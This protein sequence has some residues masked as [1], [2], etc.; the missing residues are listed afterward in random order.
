MKAAISAAFILA[1]LFTPAAAQEA[2]VG[3]TLITPLRSTETFLIDM[4]TSTIQTWHGDAGAGHTVYMLPDRSV[5]RSQ[6]DPNGLFGGGGAGGHLQRVDAN[7]NIVWDFFFSNDQHQQHHDIEPMPNGNV[8]LIAWE[9]K[10]KAEVI[11]AGRTTPTGET[12]FPTR[13]VELEPVGTN[14]AKIVWEWTLWDHLIQDNDPAKPNYGVIADHPELVDI[15]L[16]GTGRSWDHGNYVDY[17]PQR[18]QIVFS[19]RRMNE[20]YVIDHSTTIGEAAGHTGGNSGKGG[21]ILYRWGNPQNYGRGTASDQYFWGVHGANWINHGLPG[22]GG[23]LAFNNGNRPSDENDL[24]SVAE[25]QPP[26]DES[27]NYIISAGQP[28]GPAAPDW[29]YAPESPAFFSIRYG[30]AYRMPNG[31]T[32]ICD[33]VPGILFELTPDFDKVWAYLEPIGRGIFAA[34]R[35]WNVPAEVANFDI[36]PRSCPNPFNIKWLENLDGN[37]DAMLMKGGVL[38]AAIAGSA[39][40]D[41]TELDVATLRLRGIAPLLSSYQDV[42]APV[43]GDACDCTTAGPDGFTDLTL[44]FSRQEIASVLGPV[45]PGDVVTL[46]ITGAMLDGALFEATDCVTILGKKPEPPSFA[47]PAEDVLYPA[48]PNP[49]NPVTVIRYDVRAPGRVSLAV[50]DVAGRLV[51]TLVDEVQ[52][53]AAGG[54]SVTW[55]GR[56]NTDQSVASGV[57]FY[58]LVTANAAQTKK[59]MLLK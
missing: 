54:Y 58:R 5:I 4:A 7:D 17:N 25:I 9:L 36:L 50:Y 37:G 28:Y 18:D 38:P 1:M 6:G 53:P 33:G 34:Q 14:D 13:L 55:D 30:S 51:R 35:Y 26:I 32:L 56:S 11:A 41:V 21:D 48:V 22:A 57:Y 27:G 31:N 20:I 40:F 24:S 45:E 10:T 2:W 23:I 3:N 43:S 12:L 15:D 8:L 16:G 46:T 39:D 44:K 47:G 29:E 42:T 19:A 52:T 49:F 59:M